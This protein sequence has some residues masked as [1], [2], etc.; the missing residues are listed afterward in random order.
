MIFEF[1]LVSLIIAA[2]YTIQTRV[3]EGNY[4]LRDAL[5]LN[6]VY[7][8]LCIIFSPFHQPLDNSGDDTQ[9]SEDPFNLYPH[10]RHYQNRRYD[11]YHPTRYYDYGKH[12]I[13]IISTLLLQHFFTF[14]EYERFPY[15]SLVQ[16][17]PANAQAQ[18]DSPI[19][20]S[21]PSTSQ[22]GM[23]VLSTPSRTMH[24]ISERGVYSPKTPKVTNY[25][26]PSKNVHKEFSSPRTPSNPG[27]YGAPVG[28]S[29]GD[30]TAN[31]SVYQ[32]NGL[33]SM[34][35][36]Q[37]PQALQGDNSMFAAQQGFLGQQMQSAQN[38]GFIGK[39]LTP[40]KKIAQRV[41]TPKSV[42]KQGAGGPQVGVTTG[43]DKEM[44]SGATEE[45]KNVEK[46]KPIKKERT[47]IPTEGLPWKDKNWKPK[48]ND[49]VKPW[50]RNVYKI[51]FI[52]FIIFIILYFYFILL[53]LILIYIYY[54]INY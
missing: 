39:I 3:L 35:G 10:R 32:G 12:A 13:T 42:A 43:N 15:E 52:I 11:A 45:K 37:Q 14:I 8:I 30:S 2:L 34:Q 47:V 49:V 33:V 16:E 36:G 1:L 23:G 51:I 44:K 4:E 5:H 25:S 40:M 20:I 31:Q 46:K 6:G 18:Q 48:D 26:T 38:E 27:Y 17:T 54:F 7:R 24:S 29:G 28:F 50:Q 21:R 41:F 9:W 19:N 53:Y 22:Y